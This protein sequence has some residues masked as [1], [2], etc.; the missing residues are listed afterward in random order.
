MKRNSIPLEPI[1][2][3]G[4]LIALVLG[5]LATFAQDCG[6]IRQEVLRLHILANSDSQEDQALKLAVRDR[7][8]QEGTALFAQA[9]DLP[10]AVAAARES[11]PQLEQL[12][13]EEIAR[14]GFDYPVTVTLAPTFFET[15]QYDQ[16]VLPAGRYLAVRVVIGAGEGHNW[17]C[18]MYPPLC[19]PAALAPGSPQAQEIQ[20][21][22]QAP[23]CRMGF[24]LVELWEELE[25]ALAS[26]EAKPEETGNFLSQEVA[27]WLTGG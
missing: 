27:S 6:Q 7:L 25:N 22:D 24:A 11:L 3:A 18:V 1:L 10:Q 23:G 5:P 8:L 9:Q 4:L 26:R 12:A 19:V 16:Y 15:R 21:L 14:Q 17:W 2:L 20:D 13:R